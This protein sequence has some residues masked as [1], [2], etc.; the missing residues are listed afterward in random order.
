[1]EKFGKIYGKVAITLT[2]FVLKLHAP[3]YGCRVQIIYYLLL[4]YCIIT[5]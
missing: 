4:F 1:M 2:K 5:F 3:L